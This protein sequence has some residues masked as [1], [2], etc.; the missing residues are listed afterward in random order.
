MKTLYK[1]TKEKTNIKGFWQDKNKIYIDNIKQVNYS[2]EEKKKLFAS[3]ELCIF[4]CDDSMAYIEHKTGDIDMLR[5]KKLFH[6]KHITK[7]FILEL[8][9]V[10]NGFT[11]YKNKTFKDYTIEVWQ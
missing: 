1:I 3:G 11:V 9:K 7:N 10:Y 5:V 8:L 4:C 6:V 2:E